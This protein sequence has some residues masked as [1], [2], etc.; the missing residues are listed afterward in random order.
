[1]VKSHELAA[2]YEVKRINSDY[3][4]DTSNKKETRVVRGFYPRPT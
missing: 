2:T 4:S 1:M 3:L